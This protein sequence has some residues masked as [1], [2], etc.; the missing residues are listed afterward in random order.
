MFAI[1]VTLER[2]FYENNFKVIGLDK[3][4]NYSFI[5]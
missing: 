2:H 5:D 4:S 3:I 1:D